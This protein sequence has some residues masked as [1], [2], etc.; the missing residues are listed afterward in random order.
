MALRSAGD[1]RLAPLPLCCVQIP[2]HQRV[3]PHRGGKIL[4]A[5]EL[6]VKI[7]CPLDLRAGLCTVFGA[8]DVISEMQ[9]VSESAS[10]RVGESIDA[11]SSVRVGP[12]FPQC[13]RHPEFFPYFYST[14]SMELTGHLNPNSGALESGVSEV[15]GASGS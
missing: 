13:D 15:F 14:E 7:L 5:L 9:R 10:R 12:L 6:G 4:C 11:F 8:S 3:N 2:L 1:D